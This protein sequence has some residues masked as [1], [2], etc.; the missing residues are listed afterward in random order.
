MRRPLRHACTFTAIAFLLVCLAACALGMRGVW[1]PGTVFQSNGY[2]LACTAGRITFDNGPRVQAHRQRY[3]DAVARM[4]AAA[5][6]LSEATLGF[7]ADAAAEGGRA[8][9][10]TAGRSAEQS[11]RVRRY[12]SGP[13]RVRGNSFRSLGE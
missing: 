7:T 12:S 4:D 2:E 3:G 11:C 5:A 9:R 10:G 13:R 1:K 6:V 8:G